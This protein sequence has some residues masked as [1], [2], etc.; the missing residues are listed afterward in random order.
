[1]ATAIRATFVLFGDS[2]TEQSLVPEGGWGAHLASRY[3]RRADVLN[4]GFSGY[5][6]QWALEAMPYVFPAGA[7]PPALVV[8]FFGA[9][10]ASLLELNARQ[11]VP[12][13]R[14]AANLRTI[15]ALVR[16]LGAGAGANP[17]QPPPRVVLIGPPPVGHDQ[18]LSFQIQKYGSKA[19]GQLERSLENAGIY[20]AA[21]AAV[22]TAVGAPLVDLWTEMQAA[23]PDGSWTE[24][25]SDGLHLSSSGQ[26]FT[27]EALIRAIESEWPELAI[28]PCPVTNSYVN[29]GSSCGA[30]RIELPTH[31]QINPNDPHSTFDC[32]LGPPAVGVAGDNGTVELL[33]KENALLKKALSEIGRQAQLQRS[34]QGFG[35]QSEPLPLPQSLDLATDPMRLGEPDGA[36]GSIRWTGVVVGAMALSLFV[37]R[38][39]N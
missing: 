36:G 11:H 2:I 29:S 23:R 32:S 24:F 17:T 9:N 27:G 21:C 22:A 39:R 1:M 14:Y 35:G 15:V 28:Q 20:A 13:E 18:R 7:D 10:D 26:Q 16:K 38:R 19:T 37:W 4:R 3:A 8:V 6:T 30:L 34:P 33:M 12:E 31:D 5:N 25:L